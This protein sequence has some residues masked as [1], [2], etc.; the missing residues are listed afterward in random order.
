MAY[1]LTSHHGHSGLHGFFAIATNER[2]PG[3]R[4]STGW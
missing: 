3:G 1:R 4:L 2:G